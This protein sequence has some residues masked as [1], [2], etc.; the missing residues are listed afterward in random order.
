[1]LRFAFEGSELA[2]SHWHLWECSPGNKTRTYPARKCTSGFDRCPFVVGPW[3]R[4][5]KGSGTPLTPSS[6]STRL[7]LPF[8]AVTRLLPL[9]DSRGPQGERIGTV[10]CLS[11]VKA[12]DLQSFLLPP[13]PFLSILPLSCPPFRCRAPPLWVIGARS[14]LAGSRLGH[15]CRRPI[16][17]ERVYTRSHDDSELE[18]PHCVRGL[19]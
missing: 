15:G 6:G 19:I 18:C 8:L 14:V 9:A 11:E 2:W 13:S 17:F 3:P 1:M 7:S 5:K 16:L 12:T 10:V 4:E